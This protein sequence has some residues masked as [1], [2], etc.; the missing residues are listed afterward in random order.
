MKTHFKATTPT[1]QQI[2]FL[3]K[4]HTCRVINSEL[5]LAVD[6]HCVTNGRP[7][8]LITLQDVTTYY[9]ATCH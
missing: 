2:N 1:G 3:S 4:T 6:I 5:P 9:Y 8:G 7:A